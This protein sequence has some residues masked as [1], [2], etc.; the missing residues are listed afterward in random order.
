MRITKEN[1]SYHSIIWFACDTAG[2]ILVAISNEGTIPEFVA[3][4]ENR[5][6]LLADRLLGINAIGREETASV[7]CTALSAQGYYC[8]SC[9]D[10]YYGEVYSLVAT[11]SIPIALTALDADIQDLLSKQMLPID[12]SICD[13]F[14]VS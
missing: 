8:F 4:D 14:H 11:P 9:N 7:D 12:L 2:R 3:E 10:P 1:A 5:T 6:L 13:H